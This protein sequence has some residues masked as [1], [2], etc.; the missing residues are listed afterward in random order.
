M[1]TNPPTWPML[2]DAARIAGLTITGPSPHNSVAHEVALY[3]AVAGQSLDAVAVLRAFGPDRDARLRTLAG[4][5]I[6]HELDAELVRKCRAVRTA[7]S[8]VV[9]PDPAMA[10]LEREM[11]DIITRAGEVLAAQMKEKP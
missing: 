11:D 9:G 10:R 5:A 3:R 2:L 6:Q 1:S 8:P 7:P 4:A